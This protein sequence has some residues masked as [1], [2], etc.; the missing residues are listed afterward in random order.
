MERDRREIKPSFQVDPKVESE[1]T[2]VERVRRACPHLSGSSRTDEM[3]ENGAIGRA[4]QDAARVSE[5]A[6]F[7]YALTMR[8]MAPFSA[9]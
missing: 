8:H 9:I 3:D 7:G 4:V 2:S 1:R 6:S 5:S